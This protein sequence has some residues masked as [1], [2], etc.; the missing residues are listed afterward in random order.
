MEREISVNRLAISV[1]VYAMKGNQFCHSNMPNVRIALPISL[2]P[3]H[4]YAGAGNSAGAANESER[5]P[6]LE[7][8]R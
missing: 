4:L 2:L 3:H 1:S 8:A 7:F 5:I 6:R